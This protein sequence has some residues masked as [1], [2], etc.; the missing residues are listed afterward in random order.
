MQISRSGR[1]PSD[2]GPS[3]YF[4][5]SVRIDAPFNA[6]A[7]GR[8]GG[9]TVTFESGARAVWPAHPLGQML[10]VSNGSAGRGGKSTGRGNQARRRRLVRAG[11]KL[12][13]GKTPTTALS[14]IAIA[15]KMNGSSVARTEKVND[16]RYR[17]W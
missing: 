10:I 1:T 5:G 11:E 15:E 14:H 12:W 2:K 9:A 8:A 13:R 17:A 16:E 4:T 3:D 7:P 6:I